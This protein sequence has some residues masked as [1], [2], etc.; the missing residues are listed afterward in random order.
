MEILLIDVGALA[1]FLGYI[2]I[3][4]WHGTTNEAESATRQV[5]Q[6]DLAGRTHGI[7]VRTAAVSPDDR[8]APVG[9]GATGADYLD[10]ESATA[11]SARSSVEIGQCAS[12]PTQYASISAPDLSSSASSSGA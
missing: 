11:R 10:R 9:A 1:M 6:G 5:E 7:Y 2:P 3:V 12:Q 8:T 4:Y